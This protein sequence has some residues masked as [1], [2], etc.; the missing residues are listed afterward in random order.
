[1]DNW[2]ERFKN[3]FLIKGKWRRAYVPDEV[4]RFIES[5]LKKDRERDKVQ[6]LV[7]YVKDSKSKTEILINYVVNKRINFCD[8]MLP[9]EELLAELGLDPW[10]REAIILYI[11]EKYFTEG[12][13]EKQNKPHNFTKDELERFRLA[14]IE[15]GQAGAKWAALY[16][17]VK[18]YQQH[19]DQSMEQAMT[20]VIKVIHGFVE[21]KEEDLA[22]I[23][24]EQAKNPD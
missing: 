13:S 12:L 6:E 14:G 4:I 1:M 8:S 9:S 10:D 2:K 3:R 7:D 22:F 18:A 11:L 16:K 20:D 19:S 17:H 5:A 24:G 21:I 15:G 23:S